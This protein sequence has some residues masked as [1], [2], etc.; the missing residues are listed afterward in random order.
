MATTRTIEV[1][2]HRPRRIQP[3]IAALRKGQGRGLESAMEQIRYDVYDAIRFQ[4]CRTETYDY[5]HEEELLRAATRIVIFPHSG[6]CRALSTV[7]SAGAA[8]RNRRPVHLAY[9]V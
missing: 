3:V 4:C 2:I 5:Q 9:A 1:G 6:T 7:Q 8:R